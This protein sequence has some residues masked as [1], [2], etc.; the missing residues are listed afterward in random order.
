MQKLPFEIKR[1]ILVKRDAKADE[2]YGTAPDK[3]STELLLD[4]GVVNIDKPRGPTTHQI[5]DYVKKILHI[6][7]CGHSGSLDPNVTGVVIVGLGESTKI[8]NVLLS[9]GKEYVCVMH[10]HKPTDESKIRGVFKK[11][12][13]KIKQVPPIRSSVKRQLREREIYYLEILEINGQDILFKVGCQAG[14]YIRK[15]CHDIGRELGVGAHMAELRR[16]RLGPFDESTT[17]TL[18]DLTDAYVFWKTERNDKF[19]RKII[20]PVENAVGHIPKIWV[21]DT[22]VDAICHGANLNVPGIARIE[23]E[24]KAGDVAAVLTLKNELVALVTLT[25]DSEQIMKSEKGQATKTER[26]F[27]KPGIYPKRF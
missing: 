1:E 25:M 3:R 26:V 4:Y 7:K 12:V 19:L 15:L 21:T 16:T 18:Q 23:S 13:G 8:V 24:A 20:Q 10:L 22:T 5:A 9:A 14:T 2:R 11:F 17:H 27:M 6:E